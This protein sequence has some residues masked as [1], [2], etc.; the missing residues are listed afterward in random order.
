MKFATAS[1]FAAILAVAASKPE[2][3][4]SPTLPS[5]VATATDTSV[6][7]IPITVT[8]GVPTVIVTTPV[9][10]SPTTTKVPSSGN[11]LDSSAKLMMAV[12][13]GVAALAQFFSPPYSNGTLICPMPPISA[14]STS[15]NGLATPTVVWSVHVLA[16]Y[17]LLENINPEIDDI[18]DESYFVTTLLNG[19]TIVTEWNPELRLG[20]KCAV[21]H[22]PQV[23]RQAWH[24]I[25]LESVDQVLDE[26]VA[27]EQD[28]DLEGHPNSDL[29]GNN[30]HHT[31]S[32]D[33]NMLI[34]A[35]ILNFT[36]GMEE[37]GWAGISVIRG[38][39]S[40]HL[41]F[42]GADSTLYY[43]DND[44]ARIKKHLVESNTPTPGYYDVYS[45]LEKVGNASADNRETRLDSNGVLR[46]GYQGEINALHTEDV[47]EEGEEN[48]ANKA[49]IL[50]GLSKLNFPLLVKPANSSSSRGISTKSVVDTPEEAYVRAMETKRV[51]GPV[52]VE[53]YITGREF[54]ALVSGSQE[55]GITVFRVLERV[56][57]SE[58][59]E[60]ERML[61][62]D[63]K[64]GANNYGHDASVK[65]ASW[66]MQVCNDKDQD[67]LRTEARAIYASFGGNGYC[68][69]DLREDHRTG[70]LYVVDVNANCS[71]DEDE[72]CAMGKIL[73]ASGL[74]LAQ[75]ITILMA[76]AIK[77]Q[78]NMLAK[79]SRSLEMKTDAGA[80]PLVSS[81]LKRA[82][83][84]N[85]STSANMDGNTPHHAIH[86]SA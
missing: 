16:P 12:G 17:A 30:P 53:E 66:W 7:A 84:A 5:G 3:S 27:R 71:I 28:H 41:A 69:M 60:R 64:W 54:T 75:F 9:T 67:R 45:L 58:I 61:T 65:S 51:W 82:S 10:A 70:K 63:M 73:K 83:S 76:D 68:R 34:K 43:L 59:P 47:E 39:E 32:L 13:G 38:L 23:F 56:F 25:G 52:Y 74:T 1:I 55:T 36:D 50:E 2:S 19:D 8:V 29:F 11:A 31:M 46:D 78:D 40:R 42:T 49:L 62:H 26:I 72:D 57:R 6:T 18:N 86:V 35:V 85:T 44:K 77:V 33:E 81:A 80:M 79:A 4:V 48:M 15:D 24:Y 20:I 14:E 22:I 21:D 37:Q